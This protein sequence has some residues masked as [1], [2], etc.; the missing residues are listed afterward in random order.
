MFKRAKATITTLFKT[1]G[2]TAGAVWLVTWVVGF[3]GFYV[4]TALAMST[5]GVEASCWQ[6]AAVAY[7]AFALSY[8]IRVGVTVALTPPLALRLQRF[9]K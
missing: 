7:G 9:R 2:I 6:T 4:S 8:P 5:S 3:G 1:Y